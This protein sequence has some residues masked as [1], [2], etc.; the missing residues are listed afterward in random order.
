QTTSAIINHEPAALRS[1]LHNGDIVEIITSPTSRP[2]PNWLG[3]VRTGKARSAIR[4]RL[5]TANKV[6]SQAV[7][8]RLLGNALHTLGIEP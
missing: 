4:H 3:Y 2:S 1:E 8:R 5:R 6:E 7:G